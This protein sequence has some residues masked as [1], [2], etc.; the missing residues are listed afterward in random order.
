[1]GQVKGTVLTD[2]DR[3]LLA[4]VGV[5]R[6]VSAEQVH[7][8]V[9]GSSNRKLAYRRLAKLCT[10]G[11]K[12]GDAPFLRRLEFR[13]SEGTAVPVW[14][15]A[16]AGRALAEA[17]VPYLRPPAQKDVGHQFLEHTLR[18]NDVLIGL[19]VALRMSPTAP[20]AELPFRWICEEDEVLEF[21]MFHRHT[22]ASSSALLKP[23]AILEVPGRERRMFLEAETGTQSIASANPS[24]HGAV[25]HK[26]QRYA[27]FFT[28]AAGEGATTYYARAFPDGLFPVLVFLVHS[29][30]RRRRVEKAAKDWLGAQSPTSFRVRVLTFEEAAASLGTF[31][32]EGR[33]APVETRNGPAS[34]LDGPKARQLREGY[35]ALADALN[36]SRRAIA[37]HNARGG[38][39]VSLPPAPVEA[40]RSLRDLIRHDL[41]GE[42]RPAP[43]ANQGG[44][45]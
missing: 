10:A 27:H 17:A 3:M 45:R 21:E 16:P 33:A 14:A 44:S 31:I 30:E 29:P 43:A 11:S 32:R 6:Y 8:L 42:P 28:A 15:L 41:L 9:I 7:R 18:L 22:G 1:M 38:C 35:N 36:A 12:P 37:E 24:L 20:V 19:T 40:L 2:R 4:I 25:L 5:A 13:R 39:Q 23:D 34:Q 26:L